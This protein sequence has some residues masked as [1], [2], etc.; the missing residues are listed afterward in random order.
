MILPGNPDSL[1]QLTV[2]VLPQVHTA[3]GEVQSSTHTL[4]A[5]G[6]KIATEL[7]ATN[8]SPRQSQLVSSSQTATD[9]EIISLYTAC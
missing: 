7:P 3:G 8:I 1:K 2:Q 4:L 5:K 6:S 9:S